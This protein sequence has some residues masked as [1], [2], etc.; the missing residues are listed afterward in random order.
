MKLPKDTIALQ[1]YGIMI[2]I[3]VLIMV[4]VFLF[5]GR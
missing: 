4:L 5:G 3:P 1:I 2:G